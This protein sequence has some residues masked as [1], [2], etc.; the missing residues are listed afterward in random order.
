MTDTIRRLVCWCL[1]LILPM[2]A[3][4]GMLRIHVPN[5]DP[6]HKTLT[7]QLQDGVGVFHVTADH[8]A[9]AAHES[10]AP[11]SDCGHHAAPPCPD[12]HAAA[13][14]PHDSSDRHAACNACALCCLL[15]IPASLSIAPPAG[16]SSIPP[17]SDARFRSVAQHVLE[18]P[19][20][21]IAAA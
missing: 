9:G 15:L 1:M 4:A 3:M 14:E 19:P 10:L 16:V 13:K 5:A 11:R 12:C 2:Q 21:S 17:E 8:H 18:R 20:R 6:A 7:A